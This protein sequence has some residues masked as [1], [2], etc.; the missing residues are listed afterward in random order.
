MVRPSTE[1]GKASGLTLHFSPYAV[2]PYAEGP[3]TAFVPWS[4]FKDFLSPEGVALFG[5]T[6]VAG[7]ESQFE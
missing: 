3:L 2:G 1:S 6:R 7:D 4:D 5:G